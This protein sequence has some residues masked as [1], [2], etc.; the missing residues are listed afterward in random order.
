MNIYALVCNSVGCLPDGDP[1]CIGTWDECVEAMKLD[2]ADL[3][4]QGWDGLY[5]Y[6]IVPWEPKPWEKGDNF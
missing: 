6:D 4:S 2:P 5:V 3:A 1:L